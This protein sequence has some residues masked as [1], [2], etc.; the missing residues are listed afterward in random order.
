MTMQQFIGTKMINAVPMTRAEY[1][2]FRGWQLPEDENGED[3]GYLVEYLDGGKPN[4]SQYAGYVSWSP[5]EQFDKAYRPT[6]GMTFGLAL[7]ALQQG[8]R[9]A[10]TGWNGV[11]LWLEYIQASG[12]DLAFIRMSYPVHSRAYPEGARVPWL[13]SQTD[14]LATDWVVV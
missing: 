1:N 8:K 13:A 3:A 6:D 9:V 2:D 4:T 10:R 5:K 7:E 11:G 12:V 14:M